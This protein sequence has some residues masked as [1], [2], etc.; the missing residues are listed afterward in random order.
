MSHTGPPTLCHA[1]SHPP[2]G[3][4][5]GLATHMAP[6]HHSIL[7][8][9]PLQSKGLLQVAAVDFLNNF[10]SSRPQSHTADNLRPSSNNSDTRRLP[11]LANSDARKVLDEIPVSRLSYIIET[12]PRGRRRKD[13]EGQPQMSSVSRKLE[14]KRAELLSCIARPR[15]AHGGP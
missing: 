14:R 12:R 9:L 3:M 7:S 1:Y 4:G 2:S 6:I 10:R 11:P 13:E 5:G 8:K 15:W